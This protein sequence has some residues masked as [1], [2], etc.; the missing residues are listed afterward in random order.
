MEKLDIKKENPYE[1]LRFFKE[2]SNIPRKS[3]NERNIRNYLV[4]FALDR[5][6]EIYTDKY[7]NVIIRKQSNTN[8][9]NQEYIAFQAHTDMICE[10][11]IWSDHD[12]DVSPIEL[13]KDGDFIKANGTT[14]GADNGIGVAFMLALLDSSETNSLNL[15]CIF[16]VQEETTMVGVKYID[17]SIIKS[18]KIISLD[19]GKEGK[20]VINSANCMEWFGKIN[21]KYINTTNL[22]TYELNF[23]NFPGGHSGGDISDL[24][25]GN[26]IKLGF[27]ILSKLDDVYINS[28]SGGSAVNIIPRD[29]KIQFSCSKDSENFIKDEIS[30]LKNIYGNNVVIEIKKINN[31]A[32]A[33][34]QNIS[35]NIINFINSFENGALKFDKNNNQILSANFGA[36][37]EFNN[38][39][40]FEFSLRSNNVDFKES[41]INNLEQSIKENN[42]EIIWNQELYG[43]E[44]NSNIPLVQKTCSLYKSLFKK[45]MELIVT[46]GVLEGG[47]F[48]NRI[49]NLQYICIGADTF[50]AHSPSER[51]SLASIQRMWKFLKLL[52]KQEF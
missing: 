11:E 12:F 13:L 33:L 5:N 14:L 26:P 15:E 22:V 30:I 37:N 40:R 25:R 10:K 23:A 29:F 34:S 46:Q 48:Q 16:T 1:V 28:V 4:K 31:I 24:K 49:K 50:D 38:Y 44:T 45:D 41:Y 19:N 7:Y 35:Q 32:T 8:I 9:N 18:K 3:G 2:I 51:V 21:K 27:D 43:F 17:T 20:M 6:L 39:I 36:I 47:F 42:I 52:C